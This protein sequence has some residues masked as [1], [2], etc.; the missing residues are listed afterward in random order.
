MYVT[1]TRVQRALNTRKEIANAKNNG[2][3]TPEQFKRARGLL[4]KQLSVLTQDE[5]DMYLE[6]IEATS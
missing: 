1:S 4:V 3:G 2:V 5:I 6:Y